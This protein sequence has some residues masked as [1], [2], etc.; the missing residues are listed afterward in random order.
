[1]RYILLPCLYILLLVHHSAAQ[2]SPRYQPVGGTTFFRVNPLGLADLYDHNLSFGIEHR[3]SSRWAVS[4]DGAWIFYSDY[5]TEAKNAQGM[6]LRPAV[7]RYFG[8]SRRFFV[9]AEFHYKNVFYR[10]EDW[11]GR[12]AVNGVP[13]YEEYTSFLYRKQVWGFQT[14]A[15]IQF[16]ISRN[17]KFWMECY[18]GIG[19]RYREQG[20]YDEPANSVYTRATDFMFG[21][22]LDSPTD[23]LPALPLGIRF[24]Y[25]VS[26]K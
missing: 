12:D 5:Y 26:K 18:S 20:V 23:W 1:M 24:L 25:R 14:K 21:P 3:L 13:A 10:I 15:G 17:Y 4:L 8:R 9:E 6:I 16:R 7:R 19:V 22:N 11:V 2:K